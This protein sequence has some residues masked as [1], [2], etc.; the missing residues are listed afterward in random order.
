MLII[1]PPTHPRWG[2]GGVGGGN[3][4]SKNWLYTGNH[5]LI[6]RAPSYSTSNWTMNTGHSQ[7]MIT[8]E[9]TKYQTLIKELQT[10]IEITG[11]RKAQEGGD[12]CILIA[13][14]Y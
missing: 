11:G 2:W 6:L 4:P 12:I 1:T 9:F 8:N 14:S 3:R 5:S 7:N 13:D 10:K